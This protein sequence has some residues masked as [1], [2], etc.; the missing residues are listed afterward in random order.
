ML[1]F[2]ALLWNSFVL[3]RILFVVFE[4]ANLLK[5]GWSLCLELHPNVILILVFAE[6]FPQHGV[7]SDHLA[8]MTDLFLP[9]K[10]SPL[11]VTM[12]CT[13]LQ[14]GVCVSCIWITLLK[15]SSKTVLKHSTQRLRIKKN[16][17][18]V[19][20]ARH[21]NYVDRLP[22]AC[23]LCILVQNVGSEGW[24]MWN[25]RFVFL[26]R[27]WIIQIQDIPLW[28]RPRMLWSRCG[29]T[30]L[31]KMWFKRSFVRE[32]VPLLPNV[33][34]SQDLSSHHERPN[35]HHTFRVR[36]PSRQIT[37]QL[38][39]NELSVRTWNL[40]TNFVRNSF[41]N[42]KKN[43]QNFRVS[44][45][46]RAHNVNF[47]F[48]RWV[49]LHE[50][51]RLW[52]R[53][54]NSLWKVITTF[55]DMNVELSPLGENYPARRS[56][57]LGWQCCHHLWNFAIQ[58][59]GL[60]HASNN[61]VVS[62]P[63]LVRR[64]SH[65]LVWNIQRKHEKLW[66]SGNSLRRWYE[67]WKKSLTVASCPWTW[68]CGNMYLWVQSFPIESLVVRWNDDKNCAEIS[69]GMN[70]NIQSK[71]IWDFLIRRGRHPVS[72]TVWPT[73]G[74]AS[75]TKYWIK[76]SHGTTQSR[77][78]EIGE[79][80]MRLLLSHNIEE[81]FENPLSIFCWHSL[82]FNILELRVDIQLYVWQY[83]V[84]THSE[85]RLQMQVGNM[86]LFALLLTKLSVEC[87]VRDGIVLI[88]HQFDHWPENWAIN[89]NQKPRGLPEPL[90]EFRRFSFERGWFPK[91]LMSTKLRRSFDRGFAL[92]IAVWPGCPTVFA[93]SA[94]PGEPTC[95]HCKMSAACCC[96]CNVFI[97]FLQILQL[98]PF[99]S[100]LRS[101]ELQ[102]FQFVS[103]WKIQWT[104]EIV[105]WDTS[106]PPSAN[107]NLSSISQHGSIQNTYGSPINLGLRTKACRYHEVFSCHANSILVTKQ[108][109]PSYLSLCNTTEIRKL[110]NLMDT[111]VDHWKNCQNYGYRA[112]RVLTETTEK[113]HQ[114]TVAKKILPFD[115]KTKTW[116]VLCVPAPTASK[117]HI[118][119]VSL[120]SAF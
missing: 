81:E 80:F 32:E 8:W 120:L 61:Q 51:I 46:E 73:H 90:N 44:S 50:N 5:I 13:Q 12:V 64:R 7:L 100:E 65:Y 91:P 68:L 40:M 26:F 101:I 70:W 15:K 87:F 94:S 79:I 72:K 67:N 69:P 57:L 106:T 105:L 102:L 43:V 74:A 48:R 118:V 1:L 97:F 2:T 31:C 6:N 37:C 108:P 96:T 107:T 3:H 116:H 16:S 75:K 76:S 29:G 63:G 38:R 11:F 42:Q 95:L 47:H 17:K 20:C 9:H 53:T 98:L 52:I 93:I 28:W 71:E 83:V 35:S 110:R 39:Y 4:I 111:T 49:H 85:L 18:C 66:R 22:N 88:F 27:G 104:R 86:N 10:S 23:Q 59:A 55:T 78:Y 41:H 103:P 92:E 99:R 34:V 82:K 89:S 45:G 77:H 112:Q 36:G 21:V 33:L 114:I 54:L 109:Q 119:C 25:E 58:I 14:R 117:N 24:R 56:S 19:S 60:S 84:Q 113:S 30:S 115:P 62:G